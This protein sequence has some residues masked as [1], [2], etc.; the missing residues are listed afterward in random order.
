MQIDQPGV[1]AMWIPGQWVFNQNDAMFLVLHK[2]AGFNS[3]Q[4]CA[5]YFQSGAD[6]AGVS[7][8]YIIGL[9]G[10]VVQCVP[11]IYGA[12]ANCCVSPGHAPFIPDTWD[13]QRDNGNLHSISIEHIDPATDNSSTLT[14][15]QKRA[16]F[17]LIRDICKRHNIPMRYAQNDGLGGICGHRDI[18]MVNRS[19]CPGNYPWTDLLSYL[20]GLTMDYKAQQASMIW[21]STSKLLSGAYGTVAP[22]DSRIAIAWKNLCLRG[23]KPGAPMTIEYAAVDWGGKAITCQEFSGGV[24]AELDGSGNVYFYDVYGNRL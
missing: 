9:D 10:V 17:A 14:D 12:G 3:A 6:G 16:S 24:H 11:E 13:G 1:I 22:F 7:A 15:A 18:D 2:T 4:E 21:V 23:L 20:K 5:R 8:H 19:R